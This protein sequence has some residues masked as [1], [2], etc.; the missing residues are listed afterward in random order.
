MTE[1]EKRGR[2]SQVGYGSSYQRGKGAGPDTVPGI[3]TVLGGQVWTVKPDRRPEASNPCI[4]MQAG[5]VAFKECNN[6]G[7]CTTCKYDRGMRRNVE[8]NR[9][10]GWRDIMRRREGLQRTCRHTLA[11]RIGATRLGQDRERR[12]HPGGHG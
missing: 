10:G 6:F 11:H 7:D 3:K 8:Q 1:Q 5:A 4:W 2:R 12:I 9:Q